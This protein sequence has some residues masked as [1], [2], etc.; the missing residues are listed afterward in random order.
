MAQAL[1]AQGGNQAGMLGSNAPMA[2]QLALNG[3]MPQPKR[4]PRPTFPSW[5]LNQIEPAAP[6][7][8]PTD[9]VAVQSIYG[10]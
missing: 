5:L 3:Q 10:R 2:D 4:L 8:Y 9:P 6:L 7:S 1:M